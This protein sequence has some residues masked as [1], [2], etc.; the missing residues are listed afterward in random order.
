M[1]CLSGLVSL[2][3]SY[4]IE[5]CRRRW[6]VRSL[7]SRPPPWPALLLSILLFLQIVVVVWWW[8]VRQAK[9]SIGLATTN[10]W[11]KDN[12]KRIDRKRVDAVGDDVL[13]VYPVLRASFW[14]FSC[15]SD[16]VSWTSSLIP[17]A[18]VH[19]IVGR[20]FLPWRISFDRFVSFVSSS[21]FSHSPFYFLV[22]YFLLDTTRIFFSVSFVFSVFFIYMAI[23]PTG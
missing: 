22:D 1:N 8:F 19:A 11:T 20:F 14:R 10:K 12:W 9:F 18:L 13:D 6:S 15:W 17:M 21:S 3:S 5:S 7:T 2:V 23:S 16:P 4:L